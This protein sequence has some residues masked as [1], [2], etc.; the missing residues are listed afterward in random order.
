MT[1]NEIEKRSLIIRDDFGK[2]REDLF[3][4]I[5]RFTEIGQIKA[6]Y[7]VSGSR[8]SLCFPTRP[9]EVSFKH[10]TSVEG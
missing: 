6:S 2:K 1:S 10:P 3:N 9:K 5:F 4:N 8:N 7:P